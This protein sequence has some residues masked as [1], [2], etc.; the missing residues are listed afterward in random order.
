MS[1]G[2]YFAHEG[3]TPEKYS[4]T[5]K[6]LEDAGLGSPKGR[7]YHFALESDGQIQVF[8]VWNSQ[9]EFQA[10]GDKLMPIL[11]GL[12]VDPGKPMEATVHNTIVG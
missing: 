7:K 9:E 8:D 6:A 11:S 3:F 1:I 12:S 5:I 2:I 10:F 4:Q